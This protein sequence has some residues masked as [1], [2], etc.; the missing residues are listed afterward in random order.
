MSSK[1][2]RKH[3]TNQLILR[4]EKIHPA[5][6]CRRER[7]VPKGTEDFTIAFFLNCSDEQLA[8]LWKMAESKG[9]EEIV[10]DFF[11]DR[12]KDASSS[13]LS[14]DEMKNF[15][16]SSSEWTAKF[17]SSSWDELRGIDEY[18]LAITFN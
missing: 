14:C 15:D 16:F 18:P 9:K 11:K 2:D 8:Q 13:V 17:L 4:S 6:S 5:F 1:F 10:V 7:E 3:I 12:G